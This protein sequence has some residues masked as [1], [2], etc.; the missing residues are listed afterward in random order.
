MDHGHIIF[1]WHTIPHPE[2]KKTIRWY[3]L[4]GAV[5]ITFV[6]YGILTEAVTMSIA[7]LVFA[8]VYFLAHKKE[9]QSTEYQITTLGVASGEEFFAYTDI[10]AFYIVNEPPIKMLFL[11]IPEKSTGEYAIPVGGNIEISELKDVL[12]HRGLRELT[13]KQEPFINVLARI[14]KL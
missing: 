4:A 1:S 3:M 13:G 7:F 5:I 2:A 8:G 6:V 12:K 9:E 11:E 14:L 10:D